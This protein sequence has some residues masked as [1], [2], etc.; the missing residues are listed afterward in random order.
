MEERLKVKTVHWEEMLVVK[1][2]R[3]IVVS[4][5]CDLLV[6][7]PNIVT[8][9]AKHQVSVSFSAVKWTRCLVL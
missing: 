7:R 6:Q 5:D 2:N 1:R 3:E 9:E 8:E 4:H